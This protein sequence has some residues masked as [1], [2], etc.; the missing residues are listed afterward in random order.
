MFFSHNIY[1][2]GHLFSR[3]CLCPGLVLEMQFSTPPRKTAVVVVIVVF[4]LVKLRRGRLNYVG[5]EISP[6]T[7]LRYTKIF[8]NFATVFCFLNI[9]WKPI[10][11]TLK[12]LKTLQL[13]SIC[14]NLQNCKLP[15]FQKFNIS[16][17]SKPHIFRNYNFLIFIKFSKLKINKF[18]KISNFQV[19]KIFRIANYQI[20]KFSN[21]NFSKL[22]KLQIFQTF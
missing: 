2:M 18:F 11:G 3:P 16:K 17:F 7:D 12:Y 5:G 6:E 8:E 13:F 21:F 19:F 4:S 22:S 14:Q 10:W 9:S 1:V 20:Y 15:K